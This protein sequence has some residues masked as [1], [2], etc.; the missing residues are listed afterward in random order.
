MCY[1]DA[2]A[3]QI[4]QKH[5][6]IVLGG[7]VE[8]PLKAGGVREVRLERIQLEVRTPYSRFRVN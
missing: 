3:L 5:H 2:A 4:T 8:V 7:K 6:P 1:S